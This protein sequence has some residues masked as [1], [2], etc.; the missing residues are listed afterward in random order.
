MRRAIAIRFRDDSR[1][2]SQPMSDVSKWT[3]RGNFPSVIF[4]LQRY[5]T[6][7]FKE[8]FDGSVPGL[9]EMGSVGV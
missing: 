3:L 1:I 6:G 2:Y 5:V 8:T 9:L 7:H 4:A